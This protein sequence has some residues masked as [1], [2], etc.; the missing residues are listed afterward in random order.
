M[1][2]H[3]A[4]APPF[5]SRPPTLQ[6]TGISWPHRPQWPWLPSALSRGSNADTQVPSFSVPPSR[7]QCGLPCFHSFPRI[8]L[9]SIAT[10]APPHGQTLQL[11]SVS[12]S[13]RLSPL[14][15]A[16]HLSILQLPS[17]S[18]DGRT[19]FYPEDKCRRVF[20]PPTL[21]ATPPGTPLS[22][23]NPFLETGLKA[24]LPPLPALCVFLS[25]DR[26]RRPVASPLLP[27]LPPAFL[28]LSR[29]LLLRQSAQPFPSLLSCPPSSQKLF[30]RL[31]RCLSTESST[32]S[33]ESWSYCEGCRLWKQTTQATSQFCR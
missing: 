7:R 20:H 25:L 1:L 29:V 23:P 13:A 21:R 17:C 27:W 31:I 3:P 2:R 19:K 8:P 12:T 5:S 14:L 16:D 26:A 32:A 18:Q 6:C 11:F 30:P 24:P 33:G 22:P 9:P 4:S 28:L 15:T 10:P